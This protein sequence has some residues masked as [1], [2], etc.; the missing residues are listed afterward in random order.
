MNT[1]SSPDS[2]E[3]LP[4][5]QNRRT[6]VGGLATGL[7]AAAAVPAFAQQPAPAAEER[8]APKQT[9][10]QD[11][12]AQYPKPPFEKQRQDWPGLAGQMKPKPDHGEKSYQ[13]SG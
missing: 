3:R 9:V 10:K 2:P 8:S 4:T 7:A 11:P 12:T 1:S 13:G 5:M 6:F